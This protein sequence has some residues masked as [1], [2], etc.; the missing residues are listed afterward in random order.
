MS[1][2]TRQILRLAVPMT[3]EQ[4]LVFGVT[5][6][7]TAFAGGLGIVEIAAQSV[8]VRWAQFTTV[9]YNIMSV[10]ASI[11]VAQ[12]VGQRKT[13]AA[14][15]YLG[16]A[17]ALSLLS[18]AA[19]TVLVMLVSTLLVGVMGVDQAVANLG[20]PYLRLMALSFPF[21]FMLLSAL[22]CIRGAGDARTPL[23]VLTAANLLHVALVPLLVQSAAMGL[24]GIALATVISRFAGL[25]L[26]FLLLLRGVAGFRLSH[27]RIDLGAMRR[28]WQVGS[29]VGG[30]Q[31]ALRLGQLVSLRLIALLG[32]QVVAAYAVVTNTLSIL[33]TVGMGFMAA[34]LTLVGQLVGAGEISRVHVT[35]WRILYLGWAVVGSLCFVFFV[36]PQVNALFSSD[37]SVLDLAALGLRIAVISIP[38]EMCNQV[39]T[40]ALRGSG[41]TRYPMLLTLIG[42]WGIRLPLIAFLAGVVGLGLN[43]VWIATLVDTAVRT[44][45][46]LRRF[47]ATLELKPK[48]AV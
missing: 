17:L 5:L 21:N 25:L 33:L 12:A 36:F 10:G 42:Q 30:E 2:S 20:E 16:G 8:V 7:D 34:S 11:L 46:N 6:Y 26:C 41:D 23:L 27:V 29:A 24:Q 13:D 18:G 39:I 28:I 22:G 40:G 43:S 1:V 37:G 3:G 31:L 48:A 14:A 19:L 38:F 47:N 15:K 9:I 35:S 44:L 45:L 32:T 4:F